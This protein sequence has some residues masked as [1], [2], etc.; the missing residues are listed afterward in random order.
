VTNACAR[1]AV[2]SSGN[3]GAASICALIRDPPELAA[4]AASAAP[5]TARR[6]VLRPTCIEPS[7][8][9]TPDDVRGIRSGGESAGQPV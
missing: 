4:T 3:A 9:A 6:T 8:W 1:S 7:R 2:S 5:M